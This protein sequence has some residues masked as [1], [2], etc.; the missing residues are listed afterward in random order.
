MIYNDDFV[1]IHNPRTSGTSI[2]KYLVQ[3]KNAQ[4][5]GVKH[6]KIKD[7]DIKNRYAFGFVRNPYSRF[8]SFYTLIRTSKSFKSFNEWLMS[9]TPELSDMII[10]YEY[11]NQDCHVYKYEQREEALIEIAN[12]INDNKIIQYNLY[13]NSYKY[14]NEDY[15]QE[16][17]NVSYDFVTDYCKQ[18]LEK[19]NYSFE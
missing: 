7:L 4:Y 3:F 18:D 2:S 15:R 6:D 8:Y 10:Q 11:Y 17:D 14:Y 19:Y 5:T 12:N 1:F 16:Y 9:L 13:R